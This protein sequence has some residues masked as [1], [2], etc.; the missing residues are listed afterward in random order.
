MV[1]IALLPYHGSLP[2]RA[3]TWSDIRKYDDA[4]ILFKTAGNRS[5]YI[6]LKRMLLQ[7]LIS[8]K[9]VKFYKN[10]V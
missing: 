10:I 1:V 9:T 2:K 4:A 6:S 3:T 7:G 5:F 8:L